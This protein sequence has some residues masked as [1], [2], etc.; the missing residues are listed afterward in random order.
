[1]SHTFGMALYLAVLGLMPRQLAISGHA[2]KK[3]PFLPR[4]GK[5]THK[6]SL[7][8]ASPTGELAGPHRAKG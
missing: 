6:R 4:P 1:M 3:W 2:S 8:H 7:L 5:L